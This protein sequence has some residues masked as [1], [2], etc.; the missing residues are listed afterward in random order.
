MTIL[1]ND[2]LR[3]F[4]LMF[5]FFIQI[6]LFHSDQSVLDFFFLECINFIFNYGYNIVLL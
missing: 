2:L 5:D 1:K 6:W 4:T 3:R